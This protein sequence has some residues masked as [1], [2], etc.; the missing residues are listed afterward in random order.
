MTNSLNEKYR[1]VWLLACLCLY[2]FNPIYK[3]LTLPG[4]KYTSSLLYA[5]I[6]FTALRS[7]FE[8]K[9]L[10]FWMLSLALPALLAHWAKAANIY[11]SVTLIMCTSVLFNISFIAI[12]TKEML[13]FNCSIHNRLAASLCNYLFIGITFGYVYTMIE[14]VHPGSFNFPV[15]MATTK[16]MLA[17][18]NLLNTMNYHSFVTLATL[19]Y[20]EIHPLTAM[21]RC[22]CVIEALIGQIYLVVVVTSVV[23]GN[24]TQVFHKDPK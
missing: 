6:V 1:Y 12:I 21:S 2:M 8:N 7:C 23:G 22:A 15:E 20:G 9:K 11:D 16:D 19:G 17:F 14:M 10:F 13:Q 24:I 18:G 4:H 3:E 5:C